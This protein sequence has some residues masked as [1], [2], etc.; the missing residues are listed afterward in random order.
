MNDDDA[1]LER[2]KSGS[3]EAARA[4]VT[5]HMPF[6][7][8]AA[9][10]IL[11]S[12][13]DAEDAVQEAFINAFRKLHSLEDAASLPAWLHRIAVNAAISLHRRRKRAAEDPIDELLPQFDADGW[14]NYRDQAISGDAEEGLMSEERALAVQAAIDRLPET[15]RVVLVLRDLEGLSTREAAEMLGVEENALKVRL[16]R[17]RAALRS[18]LEPLWLGETREQS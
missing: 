12:R 8:Q 16:H 2:L 13:A 17:A 5:R 1:E 15:H 11:R 6:M 3:A 9:T 4:L 14:R 7:L 10:R 18:L